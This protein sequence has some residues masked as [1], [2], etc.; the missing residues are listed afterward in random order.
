MPLRARTFQ[1]N[2]SA[3]EVDPRMLGREDIGIFANAAE[4]LQNNAPLVQGGMARRPG[5]D[6][7]NVFTAHTRME[8]FRFNKSQLY[9]FAFSNAELKIFD[10]TGSL[11]QTLSTQPWNATTMWEMRITT[12]GDTTIIVHEDWMIQKLLRT[13]ASTFT[14]AD[15]EFEAHSSGY[16]RYLPF[17]KFADS[18]VTLA[19]SA[20]TGSI[21]LTTSADHFTADDVGGIVRYIGKECDVTAYTSATQVTATVRETLAGTTA[22]ADWDENVFSAKNGYARS[23][24]FHPRRL[25]FGGSRDLPNFVFSSQS[26]A[27]FNFDVGT[28]SDDES[29]Q[30]SLGLDEVNNIQHLV[31]NRHLLIFT[32]S[33]VLYLRESSTQ[34]ITPA[35]YDP[36][37]SV[38][39]GTCDVTPRRYDGAVL[40]VQDTGKVVRELLWNDLQNSYTADPVSLVSNEMINDVQQIS[41]FFGNTS[42]PEQWATLVN[43]DGTISIYHSV[44]AEKIAAWIPWDTDGTFETV[45]ELNGEI[46]VGVKRNINS[47]DV[48]YLEKFNFDRTTD[49]SAN[50]AIVS[51]TTWNGL[52]HLVAETA[53]V[54]DGNLFHGNFTV[55]GSGQVVLTETAT[56]PFAGLDFTR[57]LKDLPVVVAGPT[58]STHGLK[59]RVGSVVIRVY[60]SVNWSVDGTKFLIRQVDDDLETDPTPVSDLYEFHP[61]GWTKTGQITI[62]QTAPL[63]CT[64]LS[65]WKEVMV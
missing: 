11:L 36:N 4:N 28:G 58:G 8:R 31:S 33:A 59:K 27:F 7:L 14:I 30:G 23:V 56:A 54:V 19:A 20:T 13:G 17:Y 60:E 29:I 18:D 55:N 15:F 62:T 46:F 2:F 6:Y 47:S 65:I 32:D 57:T 9:L 38:P 64:V 12:S 3:G 44:R 50:L 22:D 52:S 34:P 1:T 5:T 25:W 43:A 53:S 45:T 61:L 26:N 35:N 49:C 51:G 10:E 37:F 42:G 40:F 21:T 63:A 48:Y 16:P 24:A 41:V 39:Y